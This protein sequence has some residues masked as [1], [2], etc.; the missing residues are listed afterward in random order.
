MEEENNNN[1][2]NYSHCDDIYKKSHSH[3]HNHG[4]ADFSANLSDNN[5]SNDGDDDDHHHFSSLSP[6]NDASCSSIIANPLNID[7]TTTTTTNVVMVESSRV[8]DDNSLSH[9]PIAIPSANNEMRDEMDHSESDSNISNQSVLTTISPTKDLMRKCPRRPSPLSLQLVDLRRETSHL[10]DTIQPVIPADTEL[11]EAFQSASLDSIVQ[12]LHDRNCH[13]SQ[14][15]WK[16]TGYTAL[17]M[18]VIEE[19]EDL[20]NYALEEGVEVL[21]KDCLGRTALHLAY[22][23]SNPLLVMKLTDHLKDC[24][25]TPFSPYS[26]S[27]AT[28]TCCYKDGEVS[29]VTSPPSNLAVMIDSPVKTST[30]TMAMTMTDCLVHDMKKEKMEMNHKKKKRHSFRRLIGKAA[31]KVQKLVFPVIQEER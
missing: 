7:N 2:N 16:E 17:H 26:R 6:R 8:E 25:S 13:I 27:S 14:I 15:L 9:T 5:S 10:K 21:Q 24:S 28:N 23:G 30:M 4:H 1:N 11:T 18:A 29:S 3:S 31:G 22:M 12:M 20:L 19:R